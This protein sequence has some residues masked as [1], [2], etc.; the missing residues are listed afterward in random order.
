[1]AIPAAVRNR[2]GILLAMV[3][4]VVTLTGASVPPEAPD[5]HSAV[6][7]LAGSPHLWFADSA[8]VL[9][10]GGDTRALAGRRI[11]WSNRI[12]VSVDQRCS[13]PA[14]DLGDP[15]LSAGL[16]KQGD[17]IY[18][19]KWETGWAQ[20]RLLH[21]L[22]IRDV[23]VFG[24]NERNYGNF[25]LDVATWEARYGMSVAGLQRGVLEPVCAPPVAGQSTQAAGGAAVQATGMATGTPGQS[26]T[27]TGTAAQTGTGGT[28]IPGQAH[29]NTGTPAQ[30]ST[31]TGTSGQSN[32]GTSTSPAQSN[33]GTP[34]LWYPANKASDPSVIKRVYQAATLW[35][36]RRGG[37]VPPDLKVESAEQ[38]TWS[39]T[40]LGCPKKLGE[41]FAQVLTPGNR[42]VLSAGGQS[43]TFHTNADASQIVRC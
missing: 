13:L 34:T 19:V 37:K 1:M 33:T 20:P 25:V 6:V 17:P 4:T 27:E 28:G 16:L 40:S 5:G 39:D 36:G 2:I 12:E 29:A 3:V 10:W 30:A 9:H 24:I 31:G 23:E 38:G 35:L 18:L 26:N 22:S 43:Y 7:G 41:A 15:W 8:G 42:V 32:T 21:I 14:S 11:A